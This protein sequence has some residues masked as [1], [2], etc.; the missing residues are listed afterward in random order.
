[1]KACYADIKNYSY[2]EYLKTGGNNC[3]RVLQENRYFK[4]FNFKFYSL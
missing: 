1:M 4:Y 3:H 2:T